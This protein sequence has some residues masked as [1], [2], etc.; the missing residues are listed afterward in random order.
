MLFTLLTEATVLLAPG[1]NCVGL[2]HGEVLHPF[3][4][5]LHNCFP[6]EVHHIVSALNCLSL[7]LGLLC[8][9]TSCKYTIEVL[10]S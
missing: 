2:H 3:P 10:I 7:S 4:C 8:I 6:D 9:A 5:G 1:K